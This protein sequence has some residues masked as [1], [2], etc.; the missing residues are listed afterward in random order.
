MLG[1][2]NVGQAIEQ[3]RPAGVDVNSGVEDARGR[4]DAT[5]MREFVV[6][7]SAALART[8]QACRITAADRSTGL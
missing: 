2:E 1:P 8:R 3:V 6:R 7:A 4:K 5:R